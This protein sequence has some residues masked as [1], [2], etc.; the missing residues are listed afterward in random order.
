MRR[1]P[2][3]RLHFDSLAGISLCIGAMLLFAPASIPL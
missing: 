1:R 2:P 3:A